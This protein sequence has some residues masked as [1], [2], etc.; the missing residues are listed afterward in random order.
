MVVLAIVVTNPDK[1]WPFNQLNQLFNQLLIN[2]NQ[3]SNYS[4]NYSW[5]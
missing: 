2:F 3:L 1:L 5:L 4:I